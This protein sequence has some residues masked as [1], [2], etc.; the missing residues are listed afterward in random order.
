MNSKKQ[1]KKLQ[2]VI[3][4]TKHQEKPSHK[5]SSLKIASEVNDFINISQT[6]I[7]FWNVSD[8][9]SVEYVSDNISIF[10]YAKELFLTGELN[11]SDIIHP[12]DY[13]QVC[14]ELSTS[15]QQHRDKLIQSYRLLTA[16]KRVRWIECRTNIKYNQDN[17]P[18]HYLSSLID[19]TESKEM[20]L[21]LKQS[22]EKFRTISENSPTGIFIYTDRIVYVNE[23][24]VEMSGYSAQELYAMSV[25]DLVT[26]PMQEQVKQM[27]L[28]RLQGE[29]FP[30]RYTDLQVISKNNV[31]RD[32]RATTETIKYNGGYA[33]L[34]TLTD[35]TDIKKTKAKLKLLAKAMEQTDELVRIT[36]KEGI[37]TYVNDAFVAH[38]GYKHIELLDHPSNILKSGQHDDAFYK[39]L[40]E[41]VLAGK[42]YSNVLANKKKDGQL[43]YEELTISPMFDDD[44]IIQNFVATGKDITQRIQMEEQ[45]KQYATTDELTRLSNRRRGNEILDIEIDRVHRYQSSFAVLMIDI[46]HFKKINDTFGHDT[47]DQVLQEISKVISLHIRKSDALMRWGGEEF[48]I[49]TAH[50]SQDE[51]IIFA[52]KLK[53]AVNSYTFDVGTDITIS[54][55][56]AI[57]RT[58][59]TKST[60]LKRVDKALYK[61]KNSGRNCVAFL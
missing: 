51:S 20:Q 26:E 7:F 39:E 48:L 53:N 4:Q 15:V 29:K 1:A 35:V 33:G 59:D 55:G 22:E 3:C 36:D 27:A 23:A 45:L 42:T 56:I 2:T 52:N 49:V 58:D 31:I 57:C 43:Y 60:L 38:S 30:Q 16:D 17:E 47:G 32:I 12:E 6:I 11:Y 41:T 25:W 8:S 18:T 44:G 46:D 61:A 5:K 40:W 10:G 14:Q 37:I 13:T 21:Q 34:G 9:L 28:R 54:I 19:I 50:M 24:L